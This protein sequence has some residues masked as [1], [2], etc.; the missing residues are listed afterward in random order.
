MNEIT[1]T[2][3]VMSF[4]GTDP[5]GGAGLQADIE[6]L[7]S[8]GCHAASVVTAVTVQDTQQLFRYQAMSPTLLIEQA[9]AV[10]EDI[11]VSAFKIGMIGSAENAEAIQSILLDYPD[12]PVVLDPLISAGGGGELAND[13]LID[14]MVNLLF[15]LTTVLTPNSEEARAFAP[16]AD[17]LDACAQELLELGSEF[18]LIT[19]S[20]ENTPHVI[21]NLYS[22]SR[23]LESYT[24]DRLPGSFHGTGCTLAAAIAG[25]LAQ[26]LPMTSAI[27]EAQEFT[28]ETLNNSYR[29]GMGQNIPNRLFW[30]RDDDDEKEQPQQLH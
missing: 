22:E 6:T 26:D 1:S 5:S 19:G 29:V 30:A 8:M 24:W 4:A 15:P 23:L 21:N 17:T 2:P 10:L 20:H 28:W 7:I 16:E 13:E 3:V 11:P 18:I 12:V 14:A 9:R 25:L 27:L